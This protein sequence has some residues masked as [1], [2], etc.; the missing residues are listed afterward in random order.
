VF[1]YDLALIDV[2]V[3]VNI[4]YFEIDKYNK[5]IRGFNQIETIQSGTKDE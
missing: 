1:N 5:K 4:V 3:S 2:I